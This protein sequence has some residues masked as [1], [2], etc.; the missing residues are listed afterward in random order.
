MF[1]KRRK[2][3]VWKG[4][5]AGLVGGLAASYAMNQFQ[6]VA[7]KIAQAGRN[8][9]RRQSGEDEDATQML[10]ERIAKGVLH[11][12]LNSR[13]KRWAG[14]LVH[15][16]YGALVGSLYGA[17]AERRIPVRALAGVPYGTALWLLGDEVGVPA[18]HL[19]KGPAQHPVS[20]H[21]MALASHVVYGTTTDL[22]RRL[23]RR[24]I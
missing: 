9:K 23:V 13:Q 6:A 5:A 3:N 18:L 11:R 21:A 2:T 4:L 7:G 15:Y 22:V 10:A 20:T 1:R 8:G 24:A 17:M 19:S 12:P 16:T 14:P